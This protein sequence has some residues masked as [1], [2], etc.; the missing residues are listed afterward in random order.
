MVG[1]HVTLPPLEPYRHENALAAFNSVANVIHDALKMLRT[2]Y[3]SVEFERTRPGCFEIAASAERLRGG[4]LVIGARLPPGQDAAAV[5]AWFFAAVIGGVPRIE[6]MLN[7]AVI[8]ARRE[9][10]SEAPEL[11]LV[12]GP[13]M[14]LFRVA[15]DPDLVME[16]ERL[17]ISH[18]PVLGQA[19]PSE[20][21]LF[22]SSS[23]D[24]DA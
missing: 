18:P 8:G 24:G 4:H 20:L 21:R 22:L 14:L 17:R 3:T 23:H 9:A 5:R 12:P 2:P 13:D 16:G 6:A 7:N 19:E 10:I 11:N 15:A 1:G